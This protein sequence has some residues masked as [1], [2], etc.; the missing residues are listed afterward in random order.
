LINITRANDCKIT[1]KIYIKDLSTQT[2]QNATA[3]NPPTPTT[4][5]QY[6]F[7]PPSVGLYPEDVDE[8]P[9]EPVDML[10]LEPI[11]VLE[12]AESIKY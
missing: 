1:P 10:P 12:G 5:S 6:S 9:L 11:V 4:A 3:N 2:N 8:T 7:S